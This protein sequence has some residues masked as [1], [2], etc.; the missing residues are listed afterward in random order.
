MRKLKKSGYPETFRR[1]ILEYGLSGFI[2]MVKGEELRLGPVNRRRGTRSKRQK[3]RLGKLREKF[4]WYKRPRG[5]MESGGSGTTDTQVLSHASKQFVPE[6]GKRG[7]KW[8]LQA[9]Q[10]PS[11]KATSKPMWEYES[12]LHVPQTP[13]G[14]LAAA[15]RAFERKRGALRH[16]RI[17]EQAGVSLNQ[18]LFSSN[19]WPGR[20]VPGR[21]IFLAGQVL[22]REVPAEEKNM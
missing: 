12:V 9:F 6:A 21:T 5:T 18:K 3:R 14:E 19:P 17:V 13:G 16:I 2:K 20:D 1:N 22:V 8:Q 7:A 10:Q 15:L 4:E 11:A